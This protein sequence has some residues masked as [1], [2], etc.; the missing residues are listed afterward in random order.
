LLHAAKTATPK[1]RNNTLFIMLVNEI[2]VDNKWVKKTKY[3]K[4]S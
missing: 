3:P 1:T 4:F 2:E